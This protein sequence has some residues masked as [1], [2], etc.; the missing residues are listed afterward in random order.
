VKAIKPPV[1]ALLFSLL[2]FT[3]IAVADEVFEFESYK[4]LLTLFEELG[5]TEAAWDLGLRD[6]NRVYLSNMPSRWRG[7][8]SKEVQ[9]RLKK[10][11]FFRVLAPLILRSNELIMQD[12]E[13]LKS[14]VDGA[15]K[16]KD[17][18]AELAVRYRIIDSIESE[19]GS[20]QLKE[21]INRVDII[22][23]SL[24]MAQTAE[25]S[26]WGTSRFADQG[27]AMFGQWAWGDKAIKPK[28][29][30]AGKGNYGIA[31]FD[32][33]QDSVSGYMMNI[34]THRAYAPL[35]DKRAQMRSK[36]QAPTGVAL[37][38]TLLNYSERGQHYV[39]TLN[40]IMSYNKLDEIDEARLVGPVILLVPAGA[41]SD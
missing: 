6:V 25:E 21:L 37:A 41:G 10:E 3:N 31:A 36:G 5:Y 16:D 2:L 24:A 38:P 35:R 28:Q 18:V 23:P 32:S 29:Q 19:V 8:S 12:R 7:K 22:P 14:F 9:V 34:N 30:R 20:E 26:G 11:L 13:R 40:S 27:N 39:D 17:W 33:P 15:D 4:E 1:V